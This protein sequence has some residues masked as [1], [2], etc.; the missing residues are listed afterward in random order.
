[1]TCATQS[2]LGVACAT[3]GRRDCALAAFAAALAANPR[4]TATYINLGVFHL[5]SADPASAAEAFCDCAGARPV[6][7]AC[8]TGTGGGARRDLAR[9]HDSVLRNANR[10]RPPLELRLS[11]LGDLRRASASKTLD[12]FSGSM[13]RVDSVGEP[14]RPPRPR[15][16][17]AP[18]SPRR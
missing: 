1:M 6:V 2:L 14:L 13:A 12:S 16:R 7:G 5:Q 10:R 4:D 11:I 18:P 8:Q 9:S 17:R 15:R 3:R